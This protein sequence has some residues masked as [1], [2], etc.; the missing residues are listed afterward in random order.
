MIATLMDY[1]RLLLGF[2]TFVEGFES[3]M[4]WEMGDGR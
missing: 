3:G 2:Y 1:V 4:D